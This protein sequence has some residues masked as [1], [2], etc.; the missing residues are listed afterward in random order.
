MPETLSSPTLVA[1]LCADWCRLC[2]S[3]RETFKTLEAQHPGCRFVWIDIEDEADLLGD[4]DIETFPTFLIGTEDQLHFVG[5]VMPQPGTAQR[6][7]DSVLL[8]RPVVQ[9]PLAQALLM[10]LQQRQCST[11]LPHSR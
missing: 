4:L 5:P 1:C 7:L 6:L 9:E 11:S 8:H 3:Y 10:Y 2:D